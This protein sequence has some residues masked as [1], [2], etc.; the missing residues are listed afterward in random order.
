MRL[1]HT[2]EYMKEFLVT[3]STTLQINRICI[4][5]FFSALVISVPM[6]LLYSGAL[7]TQASFILKITPVTSDQ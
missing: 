3:L 7:E 2:Q 4:N 5:Y 1:V 6:L